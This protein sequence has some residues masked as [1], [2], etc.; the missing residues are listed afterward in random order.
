MTGKFL[1][2]DD[3]L[4][5]HYEKSGQGPVTILLI[6]GWTMS[7]AVFSRQLAFFA[8]STQYCCITYDPRSHGKSS[9]TEGGHFYEQHGQDLN[10]LIEKL[11]LERIVLAGWSFGALEMLAYIDQFGTGRV[12]G[13]IMLDG[14]PRTVGD[15]NETDWV[16]YRRDDADG[17]QEFFT[18]GRLRD[19]DATNRSFAE[20]MLEDRS[21]DNIKWVL[22]ITDATPDSAAALLNS[23]ANFLDYRHV[24]INLNGNTP[25]LYVVSEELG[26]VVSKWAAENTSCARVEAFGAHLMFWERADEFNEVLLSFLTGVAPKRGRD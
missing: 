9:K 3:D 13:I 23:T 15:D 2:I 25:L 7:T 16:S 14:P 24:L 19:R 1:S 10:Q 5:L 22:D 21:K 6:P 18:M 17:R 4:T 26:P 8:E 20:W 11:E 12:S